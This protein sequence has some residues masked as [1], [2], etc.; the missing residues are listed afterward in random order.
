MKRLCTIICILFLMTSISAL[1]FTPMS[2]EVAATIGPGDKVH[3]V[4]KWGTMLIHDIPEGVVQTSVPV[5]YNNQPKFLITLDGL[6]QNKQMVRISLYEDYLELIKK[7][8]IDPNQDELIRLR[9]ENSQLKAGLEAALEANK[10][11]NSQ[12]I[13]LLAA[14]NDIKGITSKIVIK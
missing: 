10:S 11:L 13:I 14:I 5:T 4:V 9:A 2:H 1:S 7:V 3:A 8:Y 6:N 12:L